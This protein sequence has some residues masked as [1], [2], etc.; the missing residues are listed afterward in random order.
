[1]GS[2]AGK[3]VTRGC[4]LHDERAEIENHLVENGMTTGQI[5]AITPANWDGAVNMPSKLA[6]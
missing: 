6:A 4:H 5:A 2:S 3:S 1:M